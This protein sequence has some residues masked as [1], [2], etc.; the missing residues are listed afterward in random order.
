[1]KKTI[2]L[3]GIIVGGLLSIS[4][5]STYAMYVAVQSDTSIDLTTN[6][7]YEFNINGETS[8]TVPAASVIHFNAVIKNPYNGTIKYALYHNYT[9]TNSNITIGEVVNNKSTTT[10][11]PNTAGTI[12]QNAQKIIPIAIINNSSSSITVS[13]GL[14][15][16]YTS[17][18]LSFASNQ[19]Q[20][21][22]VVDN[23]DVANVKCANEIEYNEE[24]CYT[25]VENNI[26]NT[27]CDI[28]INS[29]LDPNLD[30]SGANAPVLADGMIPV[31]YSGG[32][33]KK[34][35][36][37]NSKSTYQWYD[38]DTQKWANAVVLVDEEVASGVTTRDYY[39]SASAGTV[40]DN[41]SILA[42]YVWIPRYKYQLFNVDSTT[43]N[44]IEIQVEFED[45]IPTKSSGT[46]NGQ[47][48]THPAFTFGTDE[49]EGIWVGKFSTTGDATT[50]TIKPNLTAITNQNVSTQFTTSQKFGTTTYLTSTGASQ[51]D[52]HMMKNT[53]W[54]AV[55]YLKQSKYGLGTT[56]IGW[57]NTSD[58]I[59]GCGASSSSSS[60][61]TCNAYNTT[62]GMLASTTGNVTGVYDMSAF[63]GTY[64]MGVMQDNTGTNTP[65][66][67]NDSSSNSGFTGKIYDSGS[68]TQYSGVSFPNSKYYDLYAYGTSYTDYTRRILGDATGETINNISSPYS[69]YGDYYNFLETSSCWFV[70][71]FGYNFTLERT[72]LFA[73]ARGNGS[74]NNYYTFRS[75]LAPIS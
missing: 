27:Y 34:A 16:G 43:M 24:S 40:I 19:K 56:D 17:N 13:F 62:N 50:P 73:L 12:A 70:R 39:T 31:Y 5:Y 71:G 68:F 22:D 37:T 36:S 15:T 59:T 21:T 9:G 23:N 18:T 55:A 49:L 41:E 3:L 72:G 44:P 25:K 64:V 54:G 45:G 51:V 26:L 60:S 20:I 38:Y 42:Y 10:T 29:V 6:L 14:L 63:M 47:W 74:S 1:M 69:W 46:A 67:G 57:N 65:M 53:E 4:F 28:L 52:A 58:K 11:A 66:S 33:W 8:F 61:T 32:S 30:K 75:V 2:V 35:D 7:N 48:L